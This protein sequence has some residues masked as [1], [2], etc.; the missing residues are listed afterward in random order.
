M[1]L[2]QVLLLLRR[3]GC[4]RKRVALIQVSELSYFTQKKMYTFNL[5]L[6]WT[7]SSFPMCIVMVD[8]QDL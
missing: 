7:T 2:I 3:E 5:M 1:A 6:L 4:G 8:L